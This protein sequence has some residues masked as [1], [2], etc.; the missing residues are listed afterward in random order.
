MCTH[1]CVQTHTKL[2][3]KTEIKIHT[4]KTNKTKANGKQSQLR[5]KVHEN[6]TEFIF[7][8]VNYSWAW[9]LPRTVGNKAMRLNRRKSGLRLELMGTR[10]DILNKTLIA[11]AL[12]PT[13]NK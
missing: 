8:L 10:K 11:Q 7:L 4:Q 9:G 12:R 1:A 5:Q 13:I 3:T 2:P 6:T